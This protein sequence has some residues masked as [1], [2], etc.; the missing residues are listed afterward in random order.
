M[1]KRIE[2]IG[3]SKEFI[4]D[5]VR[6]KTISKKRKIMNGLIITIK[7]PIQILTK[8]LIKTQW[9]GIHQADQLAKKTTSKTSPEMKI[10]ILRDNMTNLGTSQYQKRKTNESIKVTICTQFIP[11]E[12][13]QTQT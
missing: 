13:G 6:L 5:S 10:N 12:K 8:E 4:T 9:F 2:I 7:K 1:N 11:K 3:I